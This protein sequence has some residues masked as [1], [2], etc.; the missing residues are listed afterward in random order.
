MYTLLMY[1]NIYKV[2]VIFLNIY[3]TKAL[4]HTSHLSDAIVGPSCVG[5]FFLVGTYDMIELKS[6]SIVTLSSQ[7]CKAIQACAEDK[8]QQLC[9]VSD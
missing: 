2:K 5:F 4:H 7:Q 8:V 6:L 3:M 9:R 1:K